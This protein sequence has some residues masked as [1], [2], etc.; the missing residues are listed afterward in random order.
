MLELANN[1]ERINNQLHSVWE[2]KKKLD[3]YKPHLAVLKKLEEHY[4]GKNRMLPHCPVCGE[5]FYLEELNYWMGWEYGEARIKKRM[6]E[7]RIDR[8]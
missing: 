6:E 3:S 8:D 1:Y 5:P 7:Q 2:Q 4:K